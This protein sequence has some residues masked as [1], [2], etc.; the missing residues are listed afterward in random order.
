M[1]AKSGVKESYRRVYLAIQGKTLCHWLD[2]L[3]S[4]R[5]E[6][7]C[8]MVCEL[9]KNAHKIYGDNLR[10][11]TKNQCSLAERLIRYKRQKRLNN[12]IDGTSKRHPNGFSVI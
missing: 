1:K 5:S 7:G 4:I 9:S 12:G 3:L 11:K 10:P 6:Y 2:E 8:T